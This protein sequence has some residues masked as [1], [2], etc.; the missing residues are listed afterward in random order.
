[1]P[2]LTSVRSGYWND[3]TVWD[4]NA[5]P[6]DGDSVTIAAEHTVIFNVDQSS[7]PNGLAGLTIDGTLKIPSK[8]EDP[9]LPN[10]VALKVNANIAGSGSLLIGSPSDPI[11]EP[12]T[13]LILVNGSVAVAVVRAYGAARTPFYDVVASDAPGGTNTLTLQNGLPLRAGDVL[14]IGR[15]SQRGRW[16]S[17]GPPSD[18]YFTVQS[19]DPVAKTVRVTPNLS[20]TRLRD[21]L[22]CL[23]S[24]PI[25]F[26]R[27]GSSNAP[28]IGS[29][30]RTLR[31]CWLDLP[32][33]VG[34]WA[35]NIPAGVLEEM[36][37]TALT[38][39]L[40]SSG[41]IWSAQPS[42]LT[43]LV[44]VFFGGGVLLAG[45]AQGVALTNVV[46]LHCNHLGR[47]VSAQAS[48]IKAQ[49]CDYVLNETT[50]G[51]VIDDLWAV[52]LNYVFGDARGDLVRNVFVDQI[53]SICQ[54]G[55]PIVENLVCGPNVINILHG[56]ARGTILLRNVTLQGANT[57]IGV[58]APQ[59][60]VVIQNLN[61]FL[62]LPQNPSSRSGFMNLYRDDS[63]MQSLYYV[64]WQGYQD[65]P[66]A[67][68]RYFQ[69]GFVVSNVLGYP[70]DPF[71]FDFR[72]T[73]MTALPIYLDWE[74]NGA[75]TIRVTGEIVRLGA[76]ESVTVQIFRSNK[77]PLRGDPPDF[78]Q[79]VT[80]AGPI[81]LS[82]TPPD[83]GT[84][85]V[86]ILANLQQTIDPI[87]IANLRVAG[88]GDTFNIG[89]SEAVDVTLIDSGSLSAAIA[90]TESVQPTVTDEATVRTTPIIVERLE[91][92]ID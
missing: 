86:R 58:V 83:A 16:I 66:Q 14:A 43:N 80:T 61:G 11:A 57:S 46:I 33:T 17:S 52:G 42:R 59:R 39:N 30:I 48:Q 62:P 4:R 7:F 87:R 76:N 81:E 34:V 55:G 3:P 85:V 69:Y 64:E 24:R 88:G 5:V 18:L 71:T 79:M 73:R 51:W 31:G 67:R 27:Y 22:V 29:G 6:A 10:N 32:I 75:G 74:I 21:S 90:L 60:S 45:P 49:N 23:I 44:A 1:M 2:S 68:G 26:R 56:D 65:M 78:E 47:E 40:S 13:V 20:N 89:V 82:W 36:S 53:N 50:S 28:L 70:P 84:W 41:G 19:Y 72:L 91:L 37:D 54:R 63:P 38:G 12:Q 77:E 8:A 35:C 15:A 25:I 92:P 9:S